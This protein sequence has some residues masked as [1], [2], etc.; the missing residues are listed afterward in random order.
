MP[1]RRRP[2]RSKKLADTG[3]EWVCIAFGPNMKSYDTPEIRFGDANPRMITDDELGHAI[4]VAGAQGLK[5]IL[6]PTVNSADDVWRAW[7]RFFRPIT[8]EER[9]AGITGE[10][11]PWGGEPKFRTGEVKDLAKWDRWWND[12]TNYLV[13]YAKIAE[14]K[15][16]P[17]LCLGCEMN[18]TEEFE[19]KWRNLID[20]VR[21]V[22][23]GQ[24]TYDLN[25]G[26]EDTIKWLDALDFISISAVLRDSR[27]GRANRRNAVGRH[28]VR[29][30]NTH[31]TGRRARPPGPSQREV[32][33]ADPVYRVGRHAGPRMRPHS[34]GACG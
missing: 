19:G 32:G 12:Y 22:F 30:G 28:D 4:D 29:R 11:D 34:L 7:I 5:V 16:V 20:K 6:K 2:S 9:A 3:T 10:L 23:H 14:E 25:H 31:G 15:H 13:H 18:S 1:R 24:I 17:A 33:Q 8:D 26:N 21:E 27:T